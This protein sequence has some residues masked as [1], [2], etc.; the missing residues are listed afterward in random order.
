MSGHKRRFNVWVSYV[1]MF[2]NLMALLLMVGLVAAAYGGSTA[3]ARHA[4]SRVPDREERY[5][6]DRLRDR[7]HAREAPMSADCEQDLVPDAGGTEPERVAFVQFA[8]GK[9]VPCWKKPGICP[10]ARDPEEAK[11]EEALLGDTCDDIER[12]LLRNIRSM[13]KDSTYPEIRISIVGHASEDWG[14]TAYCK[15]TY[16]IAAQK[17]LTK[18]EKVNIDDQAKMF[19]NYKLSFDRA[20]MIAQHC[21][22]R[23]RSQATIFST[24]GEQ[25]LMAQRMVVTGESSLDTQVQK[26][27]SAEAQRRVTIAFHMPGRCDDCRGGRL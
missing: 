5:Y 13:L 8:M 7:F 3:G 15:D 14:N 20:S 25:K 24:P 22:I 1:D 26:A 6:M 16:F 17:R 27:F 23:W 19:C 10:V 9:A 11:R 18:E 21:E 12:L 4:C 2:S